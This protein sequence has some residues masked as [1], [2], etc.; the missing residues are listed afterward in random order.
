MTSGIQQPIGSGSTSYGLAW[1]AVTVMSVDLNTN[2]AVVVDQLT[3]SFTMPLS[4][5][6]GKGM[7]PAAGEV[8][9]LDQLYG[10]WRWVCM[11]SGGHPGGELPPS[12]I[13]ASTVAALQNLYNASW[14]NGTIQEKFLFND[15]LLTNSRYLARDH[16]AFLSGTSFTFMIMFGFSQPLTVTV[17]RACILTA[18]TGTISASLYNGS[19]PSNMPRIA[20]G[21]FSATGPVSNVTQFS[22]G[23]SVNIPAGWTAIALSTSDTAVQMAGVNYGLAPGVYTSQS[24]VH[25][26]LSSSSATA[27]TTLNMSGSTPYA[28]T[29]SRVWCALR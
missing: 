13:T 25:S 8:W 15:S 27:P 28:L 22:W 1:K 10:K 29:A 26:Q 14:D 24:G 19:D 5:W 17:G 11:V 12:P 4:S 3:K 23:G 9:I 20:T 18:G 16:I 6:R 7:S 21:S 2:T